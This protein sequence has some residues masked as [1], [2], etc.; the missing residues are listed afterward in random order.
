MDTFAKNSSHKTRPYSWCTV[1]GNTGVGGVFRVLDK[2]FWVGV[3]GVV[4]KYRGSPFSWFVAFLCD[5]LPHLLTR[6]RIISFTWL[7]YS[8]V[9]QRLSV[10][11]MG[12]VFLEICQTSY[13]SF[14]QSKFFQ[15]RE[16]EQLKSNN[17][18]LLLLFQ[19]AILGWFESEML[20][21]KNNPL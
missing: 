15:L 10:L 11:E 6:L 9:S 18:S 14:S 3:L 1:V 17:T 2:F 20:N 16:I 5:P 21:A 13:S 7:K 12:W 8:I 19:N 4:R